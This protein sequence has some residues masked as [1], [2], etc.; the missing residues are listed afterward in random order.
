[1]RANARAGRRGGIFTGGDAPGRRDPARRGRIH[2]ARA[3]LLIAGAAR[4]APV[5]RM[6]AR[7]LASS[8]TRE[9]AG[10]TPRGCPSP[11]RERSRLAF[12]GEAPRRRAFR[13]D[14]SPSFRDQSRRRR[15]MDPESGTGG[16]FIHRF[17]K[18]G[19]HGGLSPRPKMR[20]HRDALQNPPRTAR[21]R[22]LRFQ[23]CGGSVNRQAPEWIHPSPPAS[24]DA[25]AARASTPC[26]R[27]REPRCGRELPPWRRRGGFLE[28][29][30]TAIPAIR[31][32]CRIPCR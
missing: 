20:I 8:T 17:F 32:V 25:L 29:A 13:F 16:R 30:S 28:C 1:M 22:P 3:G 7:R 15:R 4:E 19:D 21:G 14:V 27:G 5:F 6:A 24:S 26:S 9:A 18:G 31:A 11:T 10:T 23:S 12:A 2:A